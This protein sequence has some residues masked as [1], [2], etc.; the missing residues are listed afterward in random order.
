MMYTF[1]KINSTQRYFMY[2]KNKE[3]AFTEM[4]LR[5]GSDHRYSMVAHCEVERFAMFVN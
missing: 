2:A 3:D 1:Q 4:K 5:F